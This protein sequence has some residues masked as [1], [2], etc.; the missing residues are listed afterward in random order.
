MRHTLNAAQVAVLFL[1]TEL[2]QSNK[3]LLES[4]HA[5]VTLD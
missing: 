5:L 3:P 1:I 2:G 4:T